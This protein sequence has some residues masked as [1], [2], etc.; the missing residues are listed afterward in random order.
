[1]D[2]ARRESFDCHEEK[3]LIVLEEAFRQRSDESKNLMMDSWASEK[4][5][6]ILYKK[7]ANEFAKR[8]LNF[9]ALF[10]VK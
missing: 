1:M 3:A 4:R 8:V 10:T 9:F 5:A 6:I 7:L 2:L